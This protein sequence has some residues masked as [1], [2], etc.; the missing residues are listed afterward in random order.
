MNTLYNSDFYGWTKTQAQLLRE[1]KWETL[2]KLNLIEEIETL[3]RQER[4]ELTNRL[5]L[6]LGHLLKWQHQPEKRSNSWLA[7]IRE[8]RTQIKRILADS[9]SLKS[10]LEEAFL[11]SYQDGINLA[12]KETNLPYETFPENCHYEITQIL[13]PEFL[14]EL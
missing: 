7:T 1:E 2:D 9:P 14:P 12:V 11:L 3:G 8:Q 5:A 6:L 13:E 10:Y 4:R